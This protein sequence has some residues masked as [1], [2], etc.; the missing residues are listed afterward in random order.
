MKTF[1][2]LC[3]IL[4]AFCITFSEVSAQEGV[5]SEGQAIGVGS[6][7]VIQVYQE[8]DLTGIYRVSEEGVVHF[9]LVEEVQA[10][11]L[12]LTEFRT[13][14]IYKLQKFIV[15]PHVSI[16]F[17]EEM[18]VV[19]DTILILGKVRSQ[20]AQEAPLGGS[21]L[22]NIIARAGGLVATADPGRVSVVRVRDGNKTTHYYNLRDILNGRK[23]DPEVKRGDIIYVPESFF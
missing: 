14:L 3:L 21:T 18:E 9:P 15:K 5:R 13:A 19:E 12:T 16:K 22:L 23:D 7:L 4:A 8:P 20:G 6:N 2:I 10:E 17:E 11:G 1:K